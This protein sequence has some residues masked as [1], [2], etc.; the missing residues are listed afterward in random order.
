MVKT[1]EVWPNFRE[2]GRRLKIFRVH[3]GAYEAFNF[4]DGKRSILDIANAMDAEFIDIG[5][6]PLDA[7]EEFINALEKANLIKIKPAP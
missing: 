5:G 4:I 1:E 6:V 3:N 2:A 7:I